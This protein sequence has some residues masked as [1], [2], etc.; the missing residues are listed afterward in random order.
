MNSNEG[1]KSVSETRE[2][3]AVTLEDVVAQHAEI[4]KELE[5]LKQTVDNA[6][7]NASRANN[8]ID[9]LE[10]RM[11]ELGRQL[12]EMSRDLGGVK[13]EVVKFGPRQEAFMTNQWKLIFNLVLLL[14]ACLII[15]GGVVGVKVAFPT[16]FGG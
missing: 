5:Y 6:D 15:V 13:D 4:K 9:R 11:E 1:G 3:N 14:A 12:S 7:D 8:R 2:V 10:I 16:L